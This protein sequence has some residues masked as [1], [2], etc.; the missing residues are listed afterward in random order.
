MWEQLIFLLFWC[1]SLS[2]QKYLQ[3]Q[4]IPCVQFILGLLRCCL[5]YIST[6]KHMYSLF[7]SFFFKM[8]HR[9]VHMPS[10]IEMSTPVFDF[11]QFMSLKCAH[12]YLTDQ[13]MSLKCAHLF[14]LWPVH[15]IKMCTPWSLL[16]PVHVIKMYTPWFLLWL[17]HV[18][19]MCTPWF[20]LWPVHV[21]KMCT[22]WFLL[23]PVHAKYKAPTEFW[24]SRKFCNF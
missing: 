8:G 5:R 18:I 19:K 6:Q 11:E 20:L 2:W 22:P 10:D 1:L 7:F 17:V 12:P 23:W 14:W 24:K 21:I 4:V 3:A 16:W 13:F 15:V 9:D